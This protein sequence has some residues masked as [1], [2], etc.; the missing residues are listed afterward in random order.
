MIEVL[1]N[2]PTDRKTTIQDIRQL[3]GEDR[4]EPGEG[5][6][7][8]EDYCKRLVSIEQVKDRIGRILEDKRTP[9]EAYD[10]ADRL[11]SMVKKQ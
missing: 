9:L 11:I 1:A 2:Y 5:K 4:C 8:V 10:V 3:K 6:G 7:K